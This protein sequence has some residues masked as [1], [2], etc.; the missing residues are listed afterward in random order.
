MP[1]TKLGEKV[2]RHFIREH[3]KTK[4][5]MIFSRWERTHSKVRIK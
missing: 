4:G 5:S 1:L 3:G 2:R